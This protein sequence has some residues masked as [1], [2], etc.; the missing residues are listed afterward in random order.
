MMA[1]A[2]QRS[3][4]I[5]VQLKYKTT[6]RTAISHFFFL[7]LKHIGLTY[8]RKV[9]IGCI[10]NII[11]HFQFSNHILTHFQYLRP[12]IAWTRVLK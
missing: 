4:F 1:T 2:F 5:Q 10:C 8:G 3:D 11:Y 6:Y 7:I 12:S 9:K